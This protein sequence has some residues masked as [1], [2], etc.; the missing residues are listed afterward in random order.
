LL[1]G[2]TTR[3]QALVVNGKSAMGDLTAALKLQ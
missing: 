2:I 3:D 1:A